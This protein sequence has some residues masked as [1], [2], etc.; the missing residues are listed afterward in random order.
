MEKPV[1][2]AGDMARSVGTAVATPKYIALVVMIMLILILN[3][4][5]QQSGQIKRIVDR[6]S[7][8][9][10]AS[11]MVAYYRQVLARANR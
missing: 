11:D 6:F 9:V 10:C 2:S 5:L 8:A 7:W 3:H 4:T 1:K